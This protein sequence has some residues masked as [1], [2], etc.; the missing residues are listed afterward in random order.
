MQVPGIIKNTGIVSAGF[1]KYLI[2][3]FKIGIPPTLKI[4]TKKNTI[5]TKIKQKPKEYISFELKD[6][7]CLLS[8]KKNFGTIV[9]PIKKK[10]NPIAN[11][12]ARL[13]EIEF[14]DNKR[15]SAKT[16]STIKGLK[17]WNFII[18]FL[19]IKFKK[20]LLG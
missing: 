11:V 20:F 14:M 17:I 3:G 2:D 8:F 6:I 16:K 1:N 15:N 10:I 18:L 12:I 19:F 7:G 9:D 4:L 5:L 13:T